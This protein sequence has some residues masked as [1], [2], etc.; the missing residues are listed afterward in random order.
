METIELECNELPF[1]LLFFHSA[2]NV[3]SILIAPAM[4]ITAQ[5]Y[6]NLAAWLSEG[7]FDVAV[8]DYI[9]T[10]RSEI[11]IKDPISF[12]DW[13][14]NIEVAGEWLKEKN[15]DVPLI[16]LGHSIGSQLFGFV[17]K[18][19]LFDKAVFLASSTGYWKDGHSPQKWVNYFLLNSVI[20]VSNFIWGYT[21]AKFF[22]K[23]ENYPK[24]PSL[25]WRRWCLNKVYLEIDLDK[26]QNNNFNNYEGKITSIWFTD[27][28]IA[29]EI[30]APK[31]V[32]IYKRAEI[33]LV[34]FNPQQFDKLKIGH[35][36]FL[37]RKFSDSLW[38]KILWYLN[39]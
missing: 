7:G 34:S 39:N 15:K 31:L 19:M 3:G 28:P 9:G 16:F 6:Y 4:G 18:Y 20:P 24:L 5:Y 38:A 32:R 22:N 2:N 27:D 12:N 37:S 26:T 23:G 14:K 11:F 17:G 1:N 10:G 36:G 21:N 8:L 30:T 25:Q 33:E 29:N 35:T 13:I